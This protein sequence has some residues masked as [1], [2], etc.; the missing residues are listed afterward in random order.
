MAQ[1]SPAKDLSAMA[2]S[3]PAKDLAGAAI[4]RESP[5]KDLTAAAMVLAWEMPA[6]GVHPSNGGRPDVAPS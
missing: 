1:A 3:S 5:A 4:V 2:Q 6:I